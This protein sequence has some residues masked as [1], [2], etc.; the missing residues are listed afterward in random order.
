VNAH[1]FLD[2]SDIKQLLS[3]HLRSILLAGRNQPDDR[4]FQ[5]GKKGLGVSQ[6][7]PGV[8]ATF[9]DILPTPVG[10]L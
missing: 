9:V 7:I 8:A 6:A 2:A 1:N 10:Q 4:A 5:P 3:N